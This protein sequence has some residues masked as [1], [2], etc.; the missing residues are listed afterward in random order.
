MKI[1]MFIGIFIWCKEN[2]I[3]KYI[4]QLCKTQA[5]LGGEYLLSTVVPPF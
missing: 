4:I 2:S 1:G 3:Y 5:R